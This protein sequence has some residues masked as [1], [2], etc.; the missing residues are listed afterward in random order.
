MELCYVKMSSKAFAPTRATPSA[1]GLDLRAAN[2]EIIN[3]QERKLIS[4]QLQ[5][6]IPEGHYGRIAPRSGLSLYHQLDVC[7]GVIDSDYRGEIRILIHNHG[8]SPFRVN[9]GDKIAQLICER[10]TIPEL[11][12]MK[13]LP[14]SLRGNK[15]FG[16]SGP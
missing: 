10:I 5:I 15:G 16:S 1:A 12:E 6:K 14:D 7:A 13:I 2:E 3:P 9:E 4:T 11:K 8:T